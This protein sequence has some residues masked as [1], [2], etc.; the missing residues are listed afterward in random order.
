VP[1][2]EVVVV[3]VAGEGAGAAAISTT[4]GLY[5]HGIQKDKL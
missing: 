1:A 5:L 2:I 4:E 3:V